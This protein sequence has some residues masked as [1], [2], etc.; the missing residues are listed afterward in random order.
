MDERKDRRQN[1]N[2]MTNDQKLTPT[3]VLLQVASLK[4]DKVI[5]VVCPRKLNV[6]I[7]EFVMF[8]LLC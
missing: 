8:N 1:N 4:T 7:Q 5:A 3:A 6:H 2:E